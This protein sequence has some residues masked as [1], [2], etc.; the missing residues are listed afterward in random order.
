MAPRE[1]GGYFFD[2]HEE[3]TWPVEAPAPRAMRVATLLYRNTPLFFPCILIRHSPQSVQ[4][5]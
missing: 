5:S 2:P 1:K 4:H 3:R